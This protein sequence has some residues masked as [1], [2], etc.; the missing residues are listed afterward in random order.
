VHQLVPEHVVVVGVDA[1]EGHHDA[2][3]QA[4]GDAARP[5]RQLVADDIR[6]LEV[7][8]VGVEHD[9]LAIEVV[10]EHVRQPHVPALGHPA[11]I[12][13]EERLGRIEVLV[14]VRRP[15]DAE[16]EPLVLHLVATEILC[17]RSLCRAAQERADQ[18]E[19]R[20]RTQGESGHRVSPRS[21][22]N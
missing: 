17:G 18:R 15:Q 16:I 21:N 7:R 6:L 14:E 11:R 22:R 10:P 12:V 8:L 5:L 19:G 2:R 20:C 9:R 3:P 1:G 4:F 13:D